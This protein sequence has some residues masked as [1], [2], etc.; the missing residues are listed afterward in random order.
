MNKIMATN[1]DPLTAFTACLRMM[2]LE[3][4][5]WAKAYCSK[6]LICATLWE[7]EN[8]RRTLL[9]PV[10]PS[11]SRYPARLLLPSHKP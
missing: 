10:G 8:E 11:G 3:E 9:R 4:F 2:S 1:Q 6:N 7:R 5:A